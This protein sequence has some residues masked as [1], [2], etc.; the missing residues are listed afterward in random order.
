MSEWFACPLCQP[1]N[2]TKTFLTVELAARTVGLSP[3]S[4]DIT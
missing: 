4:S 2:D 3:D 1:S